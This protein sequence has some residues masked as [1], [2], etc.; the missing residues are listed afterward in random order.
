MHYDILNLLIDILVSTF[1]AAFVARLWVAPRDNWDQS[2]TASTKRAAFE[3]WAKREGY[4]WDRDLKGQYRSDLTRL[5][6][7]AFNAGTAL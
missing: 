1:V 2:R 4:A 5:L 7:E 6:W 3:S